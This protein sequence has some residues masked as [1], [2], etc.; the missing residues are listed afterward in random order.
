MAA[1]SATVDVGLPRLVALGCPGAVRNSRKLPVRGPKN[2]L[3][4]TISLTLTFSACRDEGASSSSSAPNLSSAMSPHREENDDGVRS[5]M[6]TLLLR[7]PFESPCSFRAGGRRGISGGGGGGGGAPL[8]PTAA[9][10]RPA[11]THRPAGPL[12]GWGV[13]SSF[14]T[15]SFPPPRTFPSP[16][17]LSRTRRAGS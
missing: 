14:G 9:P 6:D 2:L 16:S 17:P 3:R 12:L 5:R 8:P 15:C 10:C 11:S 13:P 1:R 7:S 4:E